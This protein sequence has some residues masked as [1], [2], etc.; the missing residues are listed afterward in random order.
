MNAAAEL[1][2]FLAAHAIWCV[3]EQPKRSKPCFEVTSGVGYLR[4]HREN[5]TDEELGG[6]VARVRD[7]GWAEVYVFFKHDLDTA[8]IREL[9]GIGD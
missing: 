8:R 2:G 5:Y 1:A 7:A 9:D 3:S 6:W 4:L